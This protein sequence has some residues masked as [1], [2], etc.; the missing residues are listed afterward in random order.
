VEV[1]LSASATLR[2]SL[3]D[4]SKKT[5]GFARSMMAAFEQCSPSSFFFCLLYFPFSCY[6]L[7]GGSMRIRNPSVPA[8]PS[9]PLKRPPSACFH[10]ASPP[11]N[12]VIALDGT[13]LDEATGH[14]QNASCKTDPNRACSELRAPRI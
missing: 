4:E 12:A 10:T 1:P 9:Q 13:F 7:V 3:S 5:A 8:K 6:S 14:W 2:I 11:G